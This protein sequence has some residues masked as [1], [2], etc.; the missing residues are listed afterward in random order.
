MLT[1]EGAKAIWEIIA[2]GGEDRLSGGTIIVT[3][4]DKNT[5]SAPFTIEGI[6]PRTDGNVRLALRAEFGEDAGNFEWRERH[7]VTAKGVVLDREIR[8]SGR[9]VQ[10]AVW[11]VGVDLDLKAPSPS[12]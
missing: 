5:A 3:D 4:G 6:E 7:V 8:D 2:L 1:P 9:K 10:G 11:E 12:A